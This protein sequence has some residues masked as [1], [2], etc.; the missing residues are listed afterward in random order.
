[1]KLLHDIYGLGIGNSSYRHKLKT[2]LQ[3][4]FGEDITFHNQKK[5]TLTEI[6]ISSEYLNAETVLY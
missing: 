5:K 2:R 1:M 3:T 6:V 4:D